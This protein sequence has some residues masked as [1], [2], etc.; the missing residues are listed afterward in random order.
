MVKAQLILV[1]ALVTSV[2]A[3]SASPMKMMAA[4]V[5]LLCVCVCV[6]K[7]ENPISIPACVC[8]WVFLSLMYRFPIETFHDLYVG[9]SS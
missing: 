9:R 5:S 2:S 3:F 8:F 7:R 1:A 4:T 6:T